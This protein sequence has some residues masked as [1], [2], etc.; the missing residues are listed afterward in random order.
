MPRPIKL[1]FILRLIRRL[2]FPRKLGLLERLFGGYLS[3]KGVTW[4]TC[5]NGIFW[6]LDLTDA[7]H[8]W[9]VFGKYEGGQGID[10]AKSRLKTGGVFV[11]SGS[12]IGQWALYLGGL[13]GVRVLA[14]EPVNSQR[15]WLSECMDVQDGWDTEILPYG[16]GCDEQ[17]AEIQCDGPRSTLRMDWYGGRSFER[18]RIEIKRLDRLLE[19]RDVEKVTFW[20]LDVE[21]A[22]LDALMGA[23][24]YLTAK[25]IECIFL[26]CHPSNYESV[27]G[28]L[29]SCGYRIYDLVG[30]RLVLK[31]DLSIPGTV[32][33]IAAPSS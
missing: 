29:D 18:E 5:W 28:L 24:H 27:C 1:P 6:K 22:E 20:K 23:G 30:K 21:G 13:S 19:A 25:K 12:S 7:C 8:R 26:E 33:L 3:G 4:V 15:K 10:F 2:E 32:N 9:I 31:T 17:Y 14:F 16:L 11:D